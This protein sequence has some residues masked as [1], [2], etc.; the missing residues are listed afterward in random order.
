ME[1][2]LELILELYFEL[3]MLIVP[4]DK[5]KSKKYIFKIKRCRL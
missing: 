5:T 2:I 4:E 3:M 1:F